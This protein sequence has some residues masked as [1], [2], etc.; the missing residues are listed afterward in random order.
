MAVECYS[1]G[2]VSFKLNDIP[3]TVQWRTVA[4]EW[5]SIGR[6][7]FKLNDIPVTVQWQYSGS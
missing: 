7:S 5:Y 1:I 6:V 3:V 4:V 2:R